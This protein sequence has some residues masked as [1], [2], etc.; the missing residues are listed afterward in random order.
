MFTCDERPCVLAFPPKKN[1]VYPVGFVALRLLG[2][3]YLINI[4]TSDMQ[5]TAA[6][7]RCGGNKTTAARTSMPY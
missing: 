1:M 7:A 6:T 5:K 2:R 3:T 4:Y